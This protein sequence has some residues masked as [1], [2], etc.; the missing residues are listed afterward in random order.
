MAS[1]PSSPRP[2]PVYT[3]TSDFVEDIKTELLKGNRFTPFLGSGISAQSGIIMAQDFSDYLAFVTYRVLDARWDIRARG[4]PPHPSSDEIDAAYD[5][6]VQKYREAVHAVCGVA[7]NDAKSRKKITRLVVRPETIG[8][9]LTD[10]DV[11][12]QRPLVPYM[13]RGG[14]DEESGQDLSVSE[15]SWDAVRRHLEIKD[16]PFD[17][18]NPESSHAYITEVAIRHLSHWTRALEFLSSV[19]VAAQNRK[20]YLA[21]PDTSVIDSFNAHITRG[22]RPNL[23][24]NMIARLSRSLRTQVIL[25]TNFDTL[26]EQSYRAQGEPLH[27][28][29]VSIKG[30]LPS[31]DTVRA[32]D[33]IVKLHGDILETRA[34]SSINE[35]PQAA[36]KMRFFQYLRG[37][38]QPHERQPDDFIGSHLLV[39]GYSASDPRCVQMIKYVLDMDPAFR[40]FWVCHTEGDQRTVERLFADY[41]PRNGDL[42]EGRGQVLLIQ[43]D[44]TDLLLWELYQRINLSLPGGGYSIQFSHLV[45]PAS[46]NDDEYSMSADISRSSKKVKTKTLDP[47]QDVFDEIKK[48]MAKEIIVLDSDSGVS[49]TIQDVFHRFRKEWYDTIWFEL[50]D[51]RNTD[52]V[53]FHLLSAIAI[54]LGYFQLEWINFVPKRTD[55]KDLE[56]EDA[57]PEPERNK[58]VQ[59]N[60][61]DPEA[62]KKRLRLLVEK[63]KISP[64]RWVIFLYGRNGPGGCTGWHTSYWGKTEPER[65]IEHARFEDF[66]HELRAIGFGII[67][68]PY[69]RERFR[70]DQEKVGL[71]RAQ[72]EHCY[73]TTRQPWT[74][75]HAADAI[76]I[77]LTETDLMKCGAEKA[78]TDLA[79]KVKSKG[80]DRKHFDQILKAAEDFLPKKYGNSDPRHATRML[81]LY[82]LTLFRQSRHPAAMISESVFPCPWRFQHN[83]SQGADS[84]DNDEWRHRIVFAGTGEAVDD[85]PERIGWFRTLV[86]ARLFH[87]KPGGYAW[88]HRDTRLGLQYLLERVENLQ[89]HEE[90]FDLSREGKQ[91]KHVARM[92]K[93]RPRLHYWIGDWYLRAFYATGHYT[94]LVEAIY[95]SVQALRH[96]HDYEPPHTG[97]I[98]NLYLEQ[99]RLAWQ[100]VCQIRRLLVVGRRSLLFWCPGVDITQI[101]FDDI[102]I[103]IGGINDVLGMKK[104]NTDEHGSVDPLKVTALVKRLQDARE[105]LIEE[106]EHLNLSVIQEAYAHGG[107]SSPLLGSRE[108]HF[109]V[110]SRE[111]HPLHESRETPPDPNYYLNPPSHRLDCIDPQ[112]ADDDGGWL[113]RDML[114]R[115]RRHGAHSAFGLDDSDIARLR[116]ALLSPA[117][118]QSAGGHI[119]TI[120]GMR[121]AWLSHWAGR[122]ASDKDLFHTVWLITELMYRIVRRAKLEYHASGSKIA[123]AKETIRVLKDKAVLDEAALRLA[124][125]QLAGF[126][127][128]RDALARHRWQCICALGYLSLQL[129][130]HLSPDF[131]MADCDLR[132]RVLTMYGVALG[133]L[134]RFYEANRRLS[135]AHALV[136]AGMGTLDGR[137]LARIHLRRAE[138]LVWQARHG[139]EDVISAVQKVTA[140]AGDSRDVVRDKARSVIMHIDDAWAALERGELGLAGVS[141]STFWWYRLLALKLSCYATLAELKSAWNNR[142]AADAALNNCLPFRRRLHFPTTLLSLVRDAL[143]VGAGDVFRQI[144]VLDYAMRADDM[145]SPETSHE[146]VFSPSGLLGEKADGERKELINDINRVFE[147]FEPIN[148][149]PLVSTYWNCVRTEYQNRMNNSSPRLAL[150]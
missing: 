49:K 114:H 96:A 102:G 19:A 121:H 81:W 51:Y 149:Q 4:W 132:V 14:V 8:T 124:E 91:T 12:L 93:L 103:I 34:D 119:Q 122:S 53:F 131:H 48:R 18:N 65:A 78:N 108:I 142:E 118:D 36:D 26:M 112:R 123:P 134:N 88:K 74:P 42:V 80:K 5:F 133:Y 89:V 35:P 39:L 115:F 97:K 107:R 61:L 60:R 31:F 128:E 76:C 1:S 127:R 67:Y 52:D 101:H 59:L 85:E 9:L 135:E 79:D 70:R 33:C 10:R 138:V 147:P 21:Q 68:L 73:D 116:A 3:R 98:E 44:R 30:G 23:T 72:Y 148:Q 94:P 87:H 95:H 38:H 141:H 40:V 56:R 145:L 58:L 83:E 86:R 75:P 27:A 7:D 146:R 54:R 37:P 90:P 99:L 25:T 17:V 13:L 66:L 69:G 28:L 84:H 55:A 29:A 104:M 57:K 16:E 6:L 82:G 125:N 136:I 63:F 105:V 100:A 143:I 126:I 130:R 109:L 92:S 20:L 50:E 120:L 129:C 46:P 137:E 41:I 139:I 77:P 11:H 15:A 32:Q 2:G 24:H 71:L 62:M 22:K 117:P 113:D 64:T 106:F 110:S 144:R 43:T 111:D 150:P 45:P 47:V 140:P